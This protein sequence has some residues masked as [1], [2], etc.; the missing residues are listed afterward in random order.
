[1]FL[2]THP[3]GVQQMKRTLFSLAILAI[4]SVLFMFGPV[5]ADPVLN[6]LAIGIDTDGEDQGISPEFLPVDLVVGTWRSPSSPTN[7]DNCSQLSNAA[8]I[9]T[10]ILEVNA[11][12]HDPKPK[13]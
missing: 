9:S 3:E 13:G 11:I 12:R 1:M 7:D 2:N 5:A 4:F 6:G 8:L 10:M